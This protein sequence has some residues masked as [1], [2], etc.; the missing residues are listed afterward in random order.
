M[1]ITIQSFFGAVAFISFVIASF[2]FSAILGFI[3]FLFGGFFINGM[4]VFMKANWELFSNELVLAI[5]SL[6]VGIISFLFAV[7]LDSLDKDKF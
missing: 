3:T 6:I 7:W 1:K 2:Y 5:S 4:E